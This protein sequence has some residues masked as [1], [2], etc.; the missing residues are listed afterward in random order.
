MSKIQTRA[1]IE[2][3]FPDEWVL[4]TDPEVG[5]DMVVRSGVVVAHSKDKDEVVRRAREVPSRRMAVWFNGD[6]IPAGLKVWL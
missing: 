1:E 5:P 4:V 2:T 3:Q 6:P